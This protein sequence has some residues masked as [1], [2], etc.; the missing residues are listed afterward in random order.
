MNEWMMVCVIWCMLFWDSSWTTN[1]L[2]LIRRKKACLGWTWARR[3][4][5]WVYSL[6]VWGEGYQCVAADWTVWENLRGFF[7]ASLWWGK[8]K[9]CLLSVSVEAGTRPISPRLCALKGMMGLWLHLNAPLT[10]H[11]PTPSLLIPLPSRSWKLY[12]V[13]S[14]MKVAFF[15]GVWCSY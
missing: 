5:G 10:N 7:L 6:W 2:V 1:T 8:R 12:R 13:P 15:F 14:W 3:V 9:A 4:W 11:Q